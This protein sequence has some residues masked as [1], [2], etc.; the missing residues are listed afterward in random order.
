MVVAVVVVEVVVD[1]EVAAARNGPPS[2]GIQ[3]RLAASI[4]SFG[5]GHGWMSS[6][7]RV[8]WVPDP[9]ID[10]EHGSSWQF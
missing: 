5:F 7:M 2:M 9:G 3:A 1:V 4:A 10:N 6:M 8:R